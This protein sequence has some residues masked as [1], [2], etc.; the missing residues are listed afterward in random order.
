VPGGVPPGGADGAPAPGRQTAVKKMVFQDCSWNILASTAGNAARG[1]AT[2]EEG[3]GGGWRRSK[4]GG[5][6]N[7]LGL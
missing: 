7:D 4:S 5:N 6:G 3:G 1:G 2:R